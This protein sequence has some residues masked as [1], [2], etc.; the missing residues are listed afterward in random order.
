MNGLF[1]AIK[2]LEINQPGDIVTLG[3]TFGDFEFML[4]DAADEVVVTPMSSVPP[5]RLA[6][7]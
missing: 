2:S 4:G 6:R 1:N 7:M 5:M 3:D